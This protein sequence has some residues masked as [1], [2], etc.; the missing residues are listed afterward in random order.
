MRVCSADKSQFRF[1]TRSSWSIARYL[2]FKSCD[3][4]SDIGFWR[5]HFGYLSHSLAG[6][7]SVRA[8]FLRFVAKAAIE[9]AT[10]KMPNN[11][12]NH[13]PHWGQIT[14]GTPLMSMVEMRPTRP[15][16]THAN[17]PMRLLPILPSGLIPYLT[18]K[19]L[20]SELNWN[21]RDRRL[22]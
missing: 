2:R 14:I 22:Q 21:R 1:R 11:G 15:K 20:I 10:S 7:A 17:C 16:V 12:L 13:L 5:S 18:E 6:S 8:T 4:P 19:K 9:S 3:R